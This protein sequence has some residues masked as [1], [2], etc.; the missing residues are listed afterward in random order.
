MNY[1]RMDMW[2]RTNS[3]EDKCV[4]WC[5]DC[6]ALVVDRARHDEWHDA[7]REQ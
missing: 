1:T 2:I 4:Q 5:R 3:G 6:G 7:E